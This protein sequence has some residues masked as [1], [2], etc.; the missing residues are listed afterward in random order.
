MSVMIFTNTNV[1]TRL[2]TGKFLQSLA[3]V[4]MYRWGISPLVAC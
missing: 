2:L 4:L 3:M 1:E